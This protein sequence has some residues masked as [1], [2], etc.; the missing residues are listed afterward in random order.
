M[1]NQGNVA[2]AAGPLMPAPPSPDG[3]AQASAN[4]N[5]IAI[6]LSILQVSINKSTAITQTRE[7][8]NNT[9]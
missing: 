6:V 3:G 2:S 4:V 1:L 5:I 9:N 7:P 8:L